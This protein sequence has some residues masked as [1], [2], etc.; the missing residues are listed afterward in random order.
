MMDE[1]MDERVDEYMDEW[2]KER[3]DEWMKEL[4]TVVALYQE[5]K[6]I[7]E[8]VNAGLSEHNLQR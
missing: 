3:M 1:Q 6:K 4:E 5:M 7:E 8:P 2:V